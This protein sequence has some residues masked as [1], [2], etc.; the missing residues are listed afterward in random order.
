MAKISEGLLFRSKSNSFFICK[1]SRDGESI[2]VTLHQNMK[3][4]GKKFYHTGIPGVHVVLLEDNEGFLEN[5]GLSL[6]EMEDDIIFEAEIRGAMNSVELSNDELYMDI[7]FRACE[8][9]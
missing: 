8:L 7:N 9:A 4:C 1:Y 6:V 3:S 5:K 2:A